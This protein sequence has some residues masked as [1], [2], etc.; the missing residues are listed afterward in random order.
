MHI[1]RR[2]HM[3]ASI[4]TSLQEEIFGRVFTSVDAATITLDEI[5]GY[6]NSLKD[7]RDYNNVINST[8]KRSK[9]EGMQQGRVEG[10]AEEK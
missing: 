3:L 10:R 8:N 7:Y 5:R 2:L 6:E 9:E 4:P 1:V